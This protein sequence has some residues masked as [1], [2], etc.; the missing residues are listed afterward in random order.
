[1]PSIT[2][3]FCQIPPPAVMTE[4]M[5][6]NNGLII[7]TKTNTTELATDEKINYLLLTTICVPELVT[8]LY[9]SVMRPHH[10]ALHR[11]K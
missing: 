9:T 2:T 1:M 5:Y 6:N 8:Q 10:S 4:N 7:N 3:I 11:W